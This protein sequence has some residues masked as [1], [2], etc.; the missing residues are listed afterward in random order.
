MKTVT[1]Q[2]VKVEM[3]RD[4]AMKMVGPVVPADAK[5]VSLVEKAGK[6]MLSYRTTTTEGEDPGVKAAE[7]KLDA[8]K[9]PTGK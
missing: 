1:E 5:N 3:T 4:E 8:V 2:T 9:N 6:F 7:A